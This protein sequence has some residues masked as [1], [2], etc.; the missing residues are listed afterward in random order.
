MCLRV[1][2]LRDSTREPKYE[3]SWQASGPPAVD[4]WRDPGQSEGMELLNI[5][6]E[7]WAFGLICYQS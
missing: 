7:E 1:L 6:G 2:G 3:R 5:G 4:T